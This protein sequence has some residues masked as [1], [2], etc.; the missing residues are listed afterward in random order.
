M[1]EH[2]HIILKA[3]VKSPPKSTDVENINKWMTDLIDKISMKLLAG[4][5]TVYCDKQSNRGMT[6]VAIIETSHI[7]LHTWDE[8]NP[9]TIQL[10]IYTCSQLDILDVLNHFEIFDPISVSWL[11]I[12]RKTERLILQQSFDVVNQI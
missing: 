1:Q 9:G 4:P 3:K 10:D 5:F 12:D 2:K 6:S 7:A 8:E 11:Y